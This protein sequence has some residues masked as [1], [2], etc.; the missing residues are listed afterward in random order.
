MSYAYSITRPSDADSALEFGRL[1]ALGHSVRSGVGKG[2]EAAQEEVARQFEALLIQQFLKQARQAS[3]GLHDSPFESDQTRMAQSMG[4]EQLALQLATPGMGLAQALLDQMR[5]HGGPVAA[6]SGIASPDA[7]A[8]PSRDT[9]K[10][11][12]DTDG[13]RID[14]PSLTALIEQLT[15]RIPVVGAAFSAIQGAPRHIQ[16]FVS[17]MTDAVQT[18]AE[19][20]GIPAKLIMSQ[21]ALE[22]GWGRREIKHPDGSTTHNLFGIKAGSRWTGKVADIVTTEYENGQPRKMVQTFRAYD[23]YEEALADYA[24]LIGNSPR[25]SA[26]TQAA[27]AEEA[28]KRIHEAGYATDPSY[29]D[30]L[31]SIMRY[32]E[33]GGRPAAAGG[34][35]PAAVNLAMLER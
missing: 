33:E 22:S 34:K 8:Q 32:L 11:G 3:A 25:Y 19:G 6:S 9:A 2:S 1:D 12:Q 10:A 17:R 5:G 16:S 29:S 4:D 35:A 30:K 31:I 7:A 24:D 26:V 13:R 14:A 21:A 20:S 18:A 28:A 23:S 15:S 27:T